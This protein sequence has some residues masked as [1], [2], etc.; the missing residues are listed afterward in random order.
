[1]AVLFAGR[2]MPKKKR[3]VLM[4]SF[5]TNGTFKPLPNEGFLPET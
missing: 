5:Y 3:A 4:P 2:F 1:M